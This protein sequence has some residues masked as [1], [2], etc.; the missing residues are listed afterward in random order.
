MFMQHHNDTII[1]RRT[2]IKTQEQT[3]HARK[4]QEGT[5][6]VDFFN[7]IFTSRFI[8]KFERL[9]KVCMC[10]GAGDRT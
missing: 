1:D 8:A 7:N 6:Q 3:T 5:K 2:M 4:T 9:L 10:E